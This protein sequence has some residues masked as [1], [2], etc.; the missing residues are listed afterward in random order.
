MP[1]FHSKSPASNR[2]STV[3]GLLQGAHTLGAIASP[4]LSNNNNN[5]NNV[6]NNPI[7]G[8][9]TEP[10]TGHTGQIG[11]LATAT[12]AVA[13]GAQ[14]TS[15]SGSVGSSPPIMSS[16]TASSGGHGH[17]QNAH[18]LESP[19]KSYLVDSRS[20]ELHMTDIGQ[21]H[22]GST[23]GSGNSNI[24]HNNINNS[25]RSMNPYASPQSHGGSR[26]Q[27][28]EDYS[29]N[30]SG[31][32]STAIAPPNIQLHQATPQSTS[33]ASSSSA[34]SANVPNVL[35]P[36][37][38][39]ASSSRPGSSTTY[40]APTT[41]PTMPPPLPT[42]QQQYSP[43]VRPAHQSSHSHS[44]SS[45]AGL[46]QKYIPFSATTPTKAYSPQT[47]TMATSHS[48]LGLS[49]IRRG[50]KEDY[51][52]EGYSSHHVHD[53]AP[54][55]TKS[56]YLAPWATYAYDWCKWPVHNGNSC[57]K[58]AVASY[59]ED[60]HNFVS[61]CCARIHSTSEA[62]SDSPL[63]FRSRSSTRKLCRKTSLRLA[64][65][66]TRWTLSR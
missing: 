16:G 19:N 34:A 38:A 27:Q 46:D 61:L 66:P 10:K 29:S 33:F 48:P 47:P 22:D 20:E 45:P 23:S 13:A 11:P 17:A 40:K 42:S 8:S 32:S 56:N 51:S 15:L 4:N 52:T 1:P 6:D 39:S 43:G 21:K 50:I 9:A 63:L 24:N 65:Q 3:T 31:S 59:L 30:N 18:A 2:H 14:E 64:L 35:Q 58:M 36:G 62:N 41:I 5:N 55:Q 26:Q 49:D 28:H 53:Y 12:A 7:V 25:S 54:T 57:G 60:P 37:G 44:R